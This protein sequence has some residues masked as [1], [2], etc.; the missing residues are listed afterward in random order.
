MGVASAAADA[1][2]KELKAIPEVLHVPRYQDYLCCCR[3]VDV[4]LLLIYVDTAGV[5]L[6]LLMNP[7][8]DVEVE[9]SL[10]PISADVVMLFIAELDDAT[11]RMVNVVEI[12]SMCG[13]VRSC[14]CRFRSVT[15]SRLSVQC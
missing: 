7:A 1:T 5:K 9:L 14:S 13:N 15:K 2:L 8:D 10:P 4:S 12:F 3:S 11:L 6:I